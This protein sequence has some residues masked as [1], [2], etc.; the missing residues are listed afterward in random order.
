M[1]GTLQLGDWFG[2]GGA[3][4]SAVRET[5][6]WIASETVGVGDLD[7]G[8]NDDCPPC[9]E[10]GRREKRRLAERRVY[11]VKNSLVQVWC[12]NAASQEQE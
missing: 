8:V 2:S 12:N 3:V 5:K 4:F 1:F 7:D 10:G 11:S 9:L 6:L